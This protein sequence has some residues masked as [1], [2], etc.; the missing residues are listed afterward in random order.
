M[1]VFITN[2]TKDK[3]VDSAPVADSNRP[4]PVPIGQ[5]NLNFKND[6]EIMNQLD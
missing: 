4:R 2:Q 1:G 6:S 5:D 3:M